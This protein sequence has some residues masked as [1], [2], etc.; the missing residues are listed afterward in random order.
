[1][2]KCALET[3]RV[4][5]GTRARLSTPPPRDGGGGEHAGRRSRNGSRNKNHIFICHFYKTSSN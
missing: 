3:R 5:I 4:G 1:M 2:N